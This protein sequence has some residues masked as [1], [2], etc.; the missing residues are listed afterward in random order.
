MRGVAILTMVLSGVVPYRSLPAWMYHA[1]IPPPDRIFNPNLP[2]ITWVDL[3]FPMFI[4]AMAAAIPLASLKF[5]NNFVSFLKN[6][7]SRTF[8]LV[9][10][11]ILLHHVRPHQI[12]ASPSTQTWGLAILGF[13]LLIGLFLNAPKHWSK[14]WTY[15]IKLASVIGLAILLSLLTFRGEPFSLHRS[16]IILLVLG[17][18][19]FFTPILW[20]IGK[21]QPLWLLL[22]I[23]VLLFFRITHEQ[24]AWSAAVW[25]FTPASWLYQFYYLQYLCIAIPGL[26]AGH[27]LM[28]YKSE[29]ISSTSSKTGILILLT[30]I[31]TTLAG[32][33]LRYVWITMAIGAILLVVLHPTFIKHHKSLAFLFWSIV[34]LMA[35]GY[36]TEPYEG[37]IKKDPSTISY[38][39]ITA[40]L[41]YAVLLLM[42][43]W[44]QLISSS[45][46]FTLLIE[47]GKNPMLAYI[48]FA[49]LIWPIL[50]ITGLEV[51][52]NDWTALPILGFLRALTYTF[53][54]ALIVSFFTK[55][56]LFLKA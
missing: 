16:D 51:W 32:L 45:R 5:E 19:Y 4:F 28:K 14:T 15:V 20:W 30:L 29:S 17:N 8:A 11:S 50:A 44:E 39:F 40:G 47:N 38:Y 56:K 18:V 31:I 25:G 3:V 55:K 1:Q 10:F 22:T 52:I 49:N 7:I 42:M 9:A 34:I 36:M 43:L 26:M 48:A 27:F 53:L 46:V 54:L 33:Q 21:R 12:E 6:L 35:L 37:G 2:G 13:V 23:P 24:L 41:S